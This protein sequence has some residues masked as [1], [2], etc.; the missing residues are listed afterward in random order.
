M[1]TAEPRPVVAVTLATAAPFPAPA[2][3]A[4]AVVMPAATS[5][6]SD[7]RAGKS[8]PPAEPAPASRAPPSPSTPT[9]DIA[10]SVRWVQA[11]PPSGWLVQ[12]GIDSDVG[13]LLDLRRNYPRLKDARVLALLR[14]DGRLYYA[15]VSGPFDSAGDARNFIKD[16]EDIPSLPWVRSI[17]SLS[18]E[19]DERRGRLPGS[20]AAN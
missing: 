15:L 16:G 4:G 19:L 3:A 12:H 20:T 13:R 18:R 14:A 10:S 5:D 8:L 9:E 7:A 17:A 11:Q 1:P 2:A 6:R